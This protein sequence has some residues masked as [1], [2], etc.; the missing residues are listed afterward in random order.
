MEVGI[1]GLPKV[2]KTTLFNILTDSHQATDRYSTSTKT[3][4]GIAK[5]PDHRLELLRDLFRPRRYT[6]ATVSFVDIPGIKTGE[7]AESLDLARLRQADALMHVV[8]AF[9]DI[10]ILHPEGSVDPVRDVEHLDLELIVA[11]MELVGRRLERLGKERKR[12][13]SREEEA[14]RALLAETILPALE[15]ET[16]VR[17]LDLLDEVAQPPVRVDRPARR[18]GG[19][20]SE[21]V[22]AE[23]HGSGRLGVRRPAGEGT[24]LAAVRAAAR[25]RATLR[26]WRSS[27]GASSAWRSSRRIKRTP[28]LRNANSRRRCSRVLKSNSAMEKVLSD[29]RKVTSVPVRPSLSATAASG[30]SGSPSAKRMK[31]A[32]PP[33]KMRSSSHSERALTTETPTPCSP[34]DTL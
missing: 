5:V 27:R 30:S 15:N 9:E 24:P 3:N 26:P 8:R 32:L 16:P 6:P 34:P 20:L 10:E 13:L 23:F 28:E 14:E 12:G 29:G 31:C 7:A 1:I 21:G 4:V 19:Q 2:G 33:R 17:E 22:D 11:D 18:V 25:R